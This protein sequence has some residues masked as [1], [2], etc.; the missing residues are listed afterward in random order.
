MGT[1]DGGMRIIIET[2]EG[3]ADT[4]VR[5]MVHH[6]EKYLMDQSDKEIERE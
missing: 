6:S 4:Y 1:G 3:V 5:Q 2:A